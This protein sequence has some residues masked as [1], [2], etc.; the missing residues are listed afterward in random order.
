MSAP[1]TN[2]EKQEKRHKGPLIGMGAMVAWSVG[3]LILFVAF[4]AWSG[5][6][7]EGAETVID[8]RTGEATPA[9]TSPL[10]DTDG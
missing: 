2:I 4:M 8:G 10:A 5:D 7:P 6:S 9:E 3:L 1:E